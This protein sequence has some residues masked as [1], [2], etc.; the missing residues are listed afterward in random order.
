MGVIL[1]QLH[2]RRISLGS[3]EAFE[4]RGLLKFCRNVLLLLP[5]PQLW[6]PLEAANFV[7]QGLGYRRLGSGVPGG[8]RGPGFRV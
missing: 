1:R 7:G 4:K 2:P 3:N 8:F 5:Q 6:R